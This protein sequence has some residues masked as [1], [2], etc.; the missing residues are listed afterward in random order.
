M[1]YGTP[2]SDSNYGA[3]YD[4]NSDLSIDDHSPAYVSIT[5]QFPDQFVDPSLS[6]ATKADTFQAFLDYVAACPLLAN[7]NAA[8]K[9]ST[10][11]VVIPTEE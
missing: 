3:R 5:V 1:S 2:V 6:E 4:I 11:E 10:S 7:C 9:Y 8:K